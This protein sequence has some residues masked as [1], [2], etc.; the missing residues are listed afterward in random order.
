MAGSNWSVQLPRRQATTAPS[1]VPSTKLITVA[2][3]TSATVHG[4]APLITLATV[5]G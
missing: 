2:V 1:T 3:P 4:S 5:D